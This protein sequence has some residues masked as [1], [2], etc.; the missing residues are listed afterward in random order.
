MSILAT[1]IFRF[2]VKAENKPVDPMYG[3]AKLIYG[4]DELKDADTAIEK[5]KAYQKKHPN[6]LVYAIA[7]QYTSEDNVK[8]H[9]ALES[10]YIWHD[11]LDDAQVAGKRKMLGI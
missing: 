6:A 10:H 4:E 1:D 2:E 7:N 9:F 8:R 5:A 11:W 3:R